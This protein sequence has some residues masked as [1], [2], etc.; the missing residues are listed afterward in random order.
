MGK[1][2]YCPFMLTEYKEKRDNLCITCERAVIHFGDE[3]ERKDYIGLYCGSFHN[4]DRCSLAQSATRYYER[5]DN[6]G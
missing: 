4:W 6:N 3:K 2:I 5:I 1:T